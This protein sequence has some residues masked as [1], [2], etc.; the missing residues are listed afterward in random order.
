MGEGSNAESFVSEPNRLGRGREP[1]P[2]AAGLGDSAIPP[3]L[4]NLATRYQLPGGATIEDRGYGKWC[5]K[6]GGSVLARDDTWVWEPQPS[7][8]TDEF[9]AASRFTLQEAFDRAKAI[10]L[11]DRGRQDPASQLIS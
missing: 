8:R 2:I 7:S 1:E 10:G 4:I 6:D 11:M 3:E 9:I 5:I